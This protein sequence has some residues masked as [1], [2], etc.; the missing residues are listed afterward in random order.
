V[1]SESSDAV[2]NSLYIRAGAI[3]PDRVA[4]TPGWYL[5]HWGSSLS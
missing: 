3:A 2:V 1:V 5:I 4:A